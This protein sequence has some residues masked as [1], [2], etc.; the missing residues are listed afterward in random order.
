MA[1]GGNYFL[2]MTEVK[3]LFLEPAL[4]V[5]WVSFGVAEQI[6]YILCL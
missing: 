1:L 5:E 3:R 2:G 6:L 4:N